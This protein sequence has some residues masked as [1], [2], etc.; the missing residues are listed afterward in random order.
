MKDN[1]EELNQIFI[2][3]YK[4]KDEVTSR[5]D[6]KYVSISIANLQRDCVCR[7]SMGC[8]QV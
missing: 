4:L 8:E 7:R 5:V 6:D 2:D 1:E 3:I